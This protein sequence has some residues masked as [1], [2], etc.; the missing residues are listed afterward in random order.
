MNFGLFLFFQAS[1]FKVRFGGFFTKKKIDLGLSFY[2]EELHVT[3]T[4]RELLFDGYEDHLVDSA[5]TFSFF[6]SDGDA[7]PDKIGYMYKV[8]NVL[9]IHG[10]I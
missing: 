7:L 4:A 2:K 8:F 10:Q 3:K 5:S 9:L 1:S 6:G